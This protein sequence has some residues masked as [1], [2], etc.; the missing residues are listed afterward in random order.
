MWFSGLCGSRVATFQG[1]HTFLVGA[2]SA[3][4]RGADVL[5]T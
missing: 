4:A 2:D 3:G 5:D 1:M